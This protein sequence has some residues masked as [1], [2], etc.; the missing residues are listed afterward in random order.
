MNALPLHNNESTGVCFS[1]DQRFILKYKL[2][3]TVFLSGHRSDNLNE[4]LPLDFGL[5]DKVAS[6]L[7][8]KTIH[9]SK[10]GSF[11]K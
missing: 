3:H 9:L 6:I 8:G 10:P 2:Q 11:K 4:S 5:R 7:L 1:I